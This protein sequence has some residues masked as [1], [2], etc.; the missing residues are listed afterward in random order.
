MKAYWVPKSGS[1][2]RFIE[3]I[4]KSAQCFNSSSI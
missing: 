3:Y 1:G 4:N 2:N